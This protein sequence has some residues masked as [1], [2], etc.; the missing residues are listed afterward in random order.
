MLMQQGTLKGTALKAMGPARA[1]EEFL[2]Q[3][4]DVYAIDA[5]SCDRF[6]YNA[7]FNPNGWLM[8]L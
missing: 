2:A 4:G 3:R 1:V 7:T 8:R 6:G 5:A